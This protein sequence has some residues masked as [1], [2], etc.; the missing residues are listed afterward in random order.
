MKHSSHLRNF[1]NIPSTN[2]MIEIWSISLTLEVSQL[3]IGWLKL[4]QQSVRNALDKLYLELV[5]QLSS[6]YPHTNEGNSASIVSIS[7]FI[8]LKMSALE[9][10]LFEFIYEHLLNYIVHNDRI[11]GK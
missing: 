2:I 10:I 3:P 5:N 4:S 9:F 7:E 8:L 6:K 1:G 11:F